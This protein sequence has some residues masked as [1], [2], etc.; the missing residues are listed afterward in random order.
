MTHVELDFL[1]TGPQ[2]WNID[3][4]TDAGRLSLS[5]GGRVISVDN[6][7]VTTAQTTEYANLYAHFA[8]LVRRG[9]IDV[10]IAPLQ[11]VTDAF[12]CGRASMWSHS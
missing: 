6:E 7:P 9:C 10:D 12:M 1:Q 2:T 3:V 4:E 8:E 11:L 5:M